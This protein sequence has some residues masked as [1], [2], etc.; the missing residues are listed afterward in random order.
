MRNSPMRKLL[1]IALFLPCA[2]PTVLARQAPATVALHLIRQTPAQSDTTPVLLTTLL[3]PPKTPSHSVHPVHPVALPSKPVT[4]RVFNPSDTAHLNNIILEWALQIN[5]AIVQQGKTARLRIGP[6]QSILVHLSLR[7]PDDNNDETFLQLLYRL[8]PPSPI[9]PAHP[10][11]TTHPITPAHPTTTTHPTPSPNPTTTTAPAN[12]ILARQQLL[13]QPATVRLHVDPAG[14]LTLSDV[15]DTFSIRSPDIHLAFHKQKGW[16]IHYEVKGAV[17]LDDSLALKSN[18]WWPGY[19]DSANSSPDS[20]WLAAT[21]D[22]RLQLFA[23]TIGTGLIIIRTEYTLPATSCKLHISYTI[24]ATGEMLVA[25]Q[26]EPDTMQ[27]NAKGWPLPCFG[28]QWIL[29]AGYDSIIYYGPGN[30]GWTGLYPEKAVTPSPIQP[31][32]STGIHLRDTATRTGIRW[33]KITGRDGSGLLITAD[34]SLLNLS[35]LHAFDSDATITTGRQPARPQI[36]LSIDYPPSANPFNHPWP[37][38]MPYG[39]YQY[40][41][42]VTP[43]PPTHSIASLSSH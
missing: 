27:S 19:N 20:G 41:Y 7:L 43:V 14:E 39:S 11:T 4:L 34:S 35:A 9:P 38:V 42:K 25:Q 10:T 40:S 24:N 2:G 16:L 6:N 23:T 5:G 32:S 21:R 36:Q 31:P 18:F 33:W 15:N 37:I 26:V 17:L 3:P 29:P 1:L 8:Q 22:P 28:M 30:P 12:P 13:L